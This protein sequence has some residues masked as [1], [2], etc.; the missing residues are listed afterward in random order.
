MPPPRE[1]DSELWL[2]VREDLKST[3]AVRA[4]VDFLAKHV[5]DNRAVLTGRPS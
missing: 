5:L 2:I 4:L 3:P 1:L